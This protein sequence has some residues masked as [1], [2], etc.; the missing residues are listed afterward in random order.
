MKKFLFLLLFV[1]VQNWIDEKDG[2]PCYDVNDMD[3]IGFDA[4]D[5][6]VRAGEEF[7]IKLPPLPK[8]IYSYKLKNYD[9][10]PDEL[11][12]Y[13]YN[14]EPYITE[15]GNLGYGRL[16]SPITQYFKFKAWD[17]SY[18]KITLRFINRNTDSDIKVK[19]TI[20]N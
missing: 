13:G 17:S 12:V 1:L 11:E 15:G 7:Y 19:L 2:I 16:N 4:K 18:N 5:L 20:T 3:S 9:S 6:R 14:G 8:T 10:I